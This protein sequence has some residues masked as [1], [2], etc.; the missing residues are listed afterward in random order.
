MGYN[1]IIGNATPEFN[2]DDD[3]LSAGW[4]CKHVSLPDAPT[5]P[6]DEMTGNS[7]SRYP[8]YLAWS[9]FCKEAGIYD[10]FYDETEM[11]RGGHP[12]CVLLKKSDLERI[13]EARIRRERISTLLPGFDNDKIYDAVLARLIWLE[14]WMSWALDNCET[15]AVENS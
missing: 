4:Y 2:K 13:R 14:W 11:F 9:E 12:G 8:S 6:N 7:N 10:V 3:E 15:P 5:F 1:I